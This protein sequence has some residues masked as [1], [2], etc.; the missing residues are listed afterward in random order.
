MS[1]YIDDEKVS[2][3]ELYQRMQC[4]DLVPSRASLLDDMKEKF[5]ALKK[6]GISS[7]K[8]LRTELKNSKKL[9]TLALSSG[10]E[11]EYLILLRREI[12]GYFPKPIALKE[13][14]WVPCH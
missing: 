2:L 10:I 5:E 6:L 9:E 3:A 11:T 14:D 4:T 13:F 8:D 12:E 7:L 1:Y